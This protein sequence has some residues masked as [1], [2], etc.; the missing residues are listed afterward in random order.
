[1]E[2]GRITISRARG[3][4]FPG[5]VPAYRRDEPMPLRLSRHYNGK[6]AAH[7]ISSRYRNKIS[8]PLLDRIDIQIEVPR[9]HRM[10]CSQSKW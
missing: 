10:I 7:R 1:M 9:S 5:A 8:G 3:A 4:D 6:S 2:S